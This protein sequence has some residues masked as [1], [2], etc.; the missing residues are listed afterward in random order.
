MT[1]LDSSL[2]AYVTYE[3]RK[4]GGKLISKGYSFGDWTGCV[5]LIQIQP[6]PRMDENIF[7]IQGKLIKSVT[8]K[9]ICYV[10]RKMTHAIIKNRLA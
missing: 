8:S 3:H 1:D 6:G 4:E 5:H 2:K 10:M 9:G 7:D